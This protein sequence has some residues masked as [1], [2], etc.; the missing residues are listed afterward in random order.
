[1]ACSTFTTANARRLSRLTWTE[2]V[3]LTQAAVL[4]RVVSVAV[5]ALG[6]SRLQ[7]VMVRLSRAQ[8]PTEVVPSASVTTITWAVAAATRHARPDANCL[9]RS[10]VLCWLLRRHGAD[11]LLRIGVR[12]Q[13][14]M[15]QAHAWIE[16]DGHV[17][18]DRI[19]VGTQFTPFERAI[20]PAT[21]N[22]A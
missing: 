6:I 10:L 18:V 20:V 1:M 3:L 19:D 7:R 5:R 14:G 12:K 2:K 17:L 9:E 22:R 15:I 4:L 8:Q 13:D 16:V 11:A 21:G